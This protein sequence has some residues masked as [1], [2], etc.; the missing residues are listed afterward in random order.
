MF[1]FFLNWRKNSNFFKISVWQSDSMKRNYRGFTCKKT[2]ATGDSTTGTASIRSDDC[3]TII[4]LALPEN[5][6][7]KTGWS[8]HIS[9]LHCWKYSL[10]NFVSIP[11]RLSIRSFTILKIYCWSFIRYIF[12]LL[13]VKVSKRAKK[14]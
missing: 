3:F 5:W 14:C 8:N 1:F 4:R 11:R 2:C 6:L 12:Y 13:I 7:C 9:S 10:L